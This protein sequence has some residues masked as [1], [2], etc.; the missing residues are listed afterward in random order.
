MKRYLLLH[1]RERCQRCDHTSEQ[2]A[3]SRCVSVSLG[4]YGV[5]NPLR[6]AAKSADF[7][8]LH[9]CLLQNL[10]LSACKVGSMGRF[11]IY[12][13]ESLN[14]NCGQN[15]TA[16]KRNGVRF[17]HHQR[18]VNCQ[19]VCGSLPRQTSPIQHPR[20][21]DTCCFRRLRSSCDQCWKSNGFS[22][23]SIFRICIEFVFLFSM[24]F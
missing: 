4:F 9:S 2:A 21:G 14:V 11:V 7:L 17:S 15:L 1:C 22:L 10:S 12:T 8:H 3:D 13:A 6:S 19:P 23:R 24:F 20:V 16:F 18:R 5:G